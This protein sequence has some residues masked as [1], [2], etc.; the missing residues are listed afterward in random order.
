MH[1]SLLLIPAFLLAFSLAAADRITG[2]DF[3]TRSEVIAPHAMAA[4]SHPLATQIALDVMKQGGSAVDAAIAANAALGLMEPTSNGIGG[5]LFAIVW[6]PKTGKLY[7][8]NGSGRSP[9][10]LT[11]QE[12]RDR[13]L[14][15]IPALGPLPVS[16]PGAV[17]GW[18]AL[19]ERFGRLSMRDNLAPAIRYAREGHPVAETIAYYWGRSVPRLSKFPGFAEQFTIDGRAPRKGELWKNPNLAAT[20]QQIADGG[21]DAFY[22]G[23]IAHRIDAYFKANGGFLSY[24]DLAAHHGEWV[25][26]VG[27]NYRGYDVWELPPNS[28]GIAALQ[29]LNILETY[30]FSRIAYASAEH[31]HLFVEAKKLAFADRAHW[32]ADPAFGRLPVAKLVSKPYARQRARLISADRPL[33]EAQPATPAELDE[34]DT[35]YMTVADADGM[36]V[37]LIQSNYRGMGSGMAPTGLGFILQDRGEMFVL[38][39]CEGEAPHPNCYAPGKRPFQTIIPAFITK[40]GKPW[41]SFGV[42]GGAMQPQGHVQIVMNLVDFGMNLQEAGD[43]PRIQHDGSTEPTGQ[44]T[45]MSDGGVVQLE[46]GF[47][48]ETVRALMAMGHHVEWALGPYGGYQAIRRDADTGVYYGASESRKDGQAAGY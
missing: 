23:E 7:G 21:R 16:V 2:R 29:M 13:G 43:A 45:A 25:E 5:D 3:A 46:S 37:S 27:T 39:G 11:L 38:K 15:D 17:D 30:D 10:S 8:Y 44:N 35:I 42:M 34:G 26:P 47:A 36:M 12:F 40:D 6:D 32:Y 14:D 41:A 20:L 18:F 1:R 48:Y 24:E 33:R 31:V 28:Q 22:K 4:T 9:R 19:H